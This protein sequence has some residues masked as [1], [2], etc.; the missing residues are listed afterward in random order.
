VFRVSESQESPRERL[1]DGMPVRMS[2]EPRVGDGPK[3]TKGPRRKA[4]PETETRARRSVLVDAPPPTRHASYVT[5]YGVDCAVVAA[6]RGARRAP[7]H[8]TAHSRV[9]CHTQEK[10]EKYTTL[11]SFCKNPRVLDGSA[12]P[13]TGPAGAHG[14]MPAVARPLRLMYLNRGE[15]VT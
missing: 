12:T 1:G 14:G 5:R 7:R 6:A 2:N 10:I 11:V 13:P 8:G 3:V 15:R 4:K 9:S